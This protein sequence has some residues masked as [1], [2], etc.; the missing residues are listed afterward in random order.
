MSHYYSNEWK[1]FIVLSGKE[2]GETSLCYL[3]SCHS[4]LNVGFLKTIENVK[5][6]S[7]YF[8]P[9]ANHVI[10]LSYFIG[11]ET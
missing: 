7:I 3:V 2:Q 1:G 9:L 8:L 11:K 6:F 4:F 10:D 5:N